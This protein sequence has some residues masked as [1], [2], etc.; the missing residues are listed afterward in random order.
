MAS[1]LCETTEDVKY[2]GKKLYYLIIVAVF[3]TNITQIPFLIGVRYIKLLSYAPWIFVFLY[4]IFLRNKRRIG[5][6]FKSQAHVY[7]LLGVVFSICVILE[8][9]SLEG[10]GVNL[11][12]PILISVFIYTIAVN[13]GF[14]LTDDEIKNI[15]YCYIISSM[16]VATFVYFE[17]L[18]SGFKWNNIAYAYGSKNSVS[19]IILTAIFLSL[20]LT[21]KRKGKSIVF[22]D[23][24]SLL[25]I[26]LLFMMKSR[27]TLVGLVIIL[28]FV[29]FGEGYNKSVKFV[30]VF[31]TLAFVGILVF[32]QTFRNDFIEQVIF[33]NRS[34]AGLDDIS[35]GR[36]TQLSGFPK[37]FSE[38]PILGHGRDYIESMFFDAFL[39]LGLVGGI[40]VNVL[41]LTPVV[42]SI[43]NYRRNKDWLNYMVFVVS[44]CYYVNGL[45][46]QLAPFGPGVKCYFLWLIH[47]ITV[48]FNVKRERTT[49]KYLTKAV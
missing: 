12:M 11:L 25:M 34:G 40:A 10:L 38:K 18:A 9:L 29:L 17:I 48:A 27:A 47:G 49:T 31:I 39:E 5:F 26:V 20:F 14:L 16:I 3:F 6:Y 24:A 15:C 22:V 37:R 4:L 32:N 28:L 42:Y 44:L 30:I 1:I 41:A 8:F 36:I 46:E 21:G 33:A 2:M 45:F 23:V 7:F 13:S 19:Q 35:S 43:K